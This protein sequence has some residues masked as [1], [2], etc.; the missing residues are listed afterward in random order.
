M[1]SIKIKILISILT[2]FA[3]FCHLRW[4]MCI[5]VQFE[6]RG[7]AD[8]SL[9]RSG[10]K[11][12]TVT[13][14]GIYSTYSP[15]SSVHF[16]ARCSNFCKPLKKN[17]NVV[18]PTMFA[19]QQWPPRQT[20]N[21]DLSI[22]FSV[23]GMGGSPTGPDSENMVGDQD[24]GSTGRPVSSGL[25]VLGEPWHCPARTKGPLVTFL[26][27]GV[28]PSKCPSIAPTEMSNTPRW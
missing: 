4:L 14:L 13:I 17:Q 15:R 10:R 26:R 2:C 12:A 16:L 8:K 19:R 21:G 9:A 3:F 20:K 23:Q 25:H 5:R 24:T 22:V 27:C 6:L 18:R 7:S 28:F 11:Q 1:I